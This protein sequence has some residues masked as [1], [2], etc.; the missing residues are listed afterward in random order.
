ILSPISVVSAECRRELDFAVEKGK[1]LLP[2]VLRDVEAGKGPFSLG[3]RDYI[4]FRDGEGVEAAFRLFLVAIEADL[5]WVRFHTD[6]LERATQWADSGHNKGNLL[7]GPML[8]SAERWVERSRDLNRP[9]LTPD[10]LRLV[11]AS[12][13]AVNRSRFGLFM[14]LV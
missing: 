10:Q 14:G 6:L 4:A 2:V 7:R 12:R 13:R 5:E 3:G 8:T 11:Q 1:R 9:K